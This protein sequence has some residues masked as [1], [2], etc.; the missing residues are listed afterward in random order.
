MQFSVLVTYKKF[1][2]EIKKENRRVTE[3]SAFFS[4]LSEQ[5]VTFISNS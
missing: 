2:A 5:Y 4:E 3:G 1:V